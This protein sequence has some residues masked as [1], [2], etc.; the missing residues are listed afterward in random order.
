MAKIKRLKEYMRSGGI[1][2]AG[3]GV[4]HIQPMASL[5]DSPPKGHGS[6]RGRLQAS[7]IKTK[8]RLE[9]KKIKESSLYK[10]MVRLGKLKG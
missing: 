4:A 3:V 1:G 10:Y 8:K 5:G 2:A 7:T 6:P 9:K